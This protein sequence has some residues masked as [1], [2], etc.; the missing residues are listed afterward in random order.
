MVNGTSTR[1]LCEPSVFGWTILRM[2]VKQEITSIG[3]TTF[4]PE[5]VWAKGSSI[6]GLLY[7]FIC[8]HLHHIFITSSSHLHHIFTSSHLR[9]FTLSSSHLLSLSLS[10]S[11]SL[12]L[13]LFSSSHLLIFT[14]SHLFSLSLS[15]SL[16]LSLPLSLCPSVPLS[17]CLSVSLSLCLSVSL[18]LSLSLSLCLLPSVTVSLLLFLFSLKAAGSADEAPRSGHPFAR[19]EVWVSKT[20]G[21]L[22]VWLVRRQPFRT[23]R[24]V[25]VQNGVFLRVWLV[26]LK[27]LRVQVLVC[28]SVC[29]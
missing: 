7:I 23:K 8:S 6:G 24:G 27:G 12:P 20:D 14:S 5:S 10:L 1:F 17:L 26:L 29:V 21:C 9:I 13:L 22:R 2:G 18:S 25:S 19:N 16:S 11:F 4:F 28:K 15:P 3:L